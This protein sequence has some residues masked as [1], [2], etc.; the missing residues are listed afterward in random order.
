MTSWSVYI[1]RCHDKSLYTG[2][3]TNVEKRLQTHNQGKGAAYTRTRRP[4]ILLWQET[5][6]SESAARKREHQIKRWT[7]KQ[8]EEFINQKT[9]LS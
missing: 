2:I 4:V 9:V 5:V 3:S 8:K 6:D 7:K 1:L